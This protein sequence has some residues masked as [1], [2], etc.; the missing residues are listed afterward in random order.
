[1]KTAAC[2]LMLCILTAV[3]FAQDH[4]ALTAF[5]NS[6]YAGADGKYESA[7]DTAVLQFN[8]SV[9]E[10]TS[11]AAYQHAAKDV[12]EVRQ[13]LRANGIEPKAANI[14]SLSVQPMYDWKNAKQRVIGYPRGCRR[15]PQTKRFFEDWPHHP[16]TCRSQ[17]QRE[18]DAELHAGEYGRSE[19]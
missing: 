3:S 8:I 11:Q 12:E 6:V 16:A 9:Q 1:M 5:P 2:L 7:P 13:V 19:E 17:R 15:Y 18:T 14:G 10:D 4:P